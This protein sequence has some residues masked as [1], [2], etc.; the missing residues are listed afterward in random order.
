MADVQ[1]KRMDSR[2][3]KSQIRM[4]HAYFMLCEA[5]LRISVASI[6]KAAGVTRG[7]F[8]QHY[9]DKETF[10]RAVINDT[11]ADF[12][13]TVIHTRVGD[14]APARL[15]LSL[16]LAELARHD[17]GFALL[18]SQ[19]G[20]QNFYVC[21]AKAIETAI[22]TYLTTSQV[23]ILTNQFEVDDIIV[24]IANMMVD[25]F[26]DWVFQNPRRRNPEY[27]D[28]LIRKL[29]QADTLGVFDMSHF[30]Y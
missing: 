8:Y 16:A 4:R 20:K 18:F 3:R 27:T 30:F 17:N 29:C 5:N 9:P 28:S 19:N 12:M 21:F 14:E 15:N 11:I 1:Q 10:E 24:V 13:E 26:R 23:E 7:T 22:K 25:Q 6:A 2:I